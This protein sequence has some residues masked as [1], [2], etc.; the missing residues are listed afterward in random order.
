MATGLEAGIARLRARHQPRVCDDGDS[1]T[2]FVSRLK[3][4]REEFKRDHPLPPLP[5]GAADAAS[6]RQHVAPSPPPEEMEE[7]PPPSLPPPYELLVESPDGDV[8]PYLVDLLVYCLVSGGCDRAAPPARTGAHASIN[9]RERAGR[10]RG[11]RAFLPGSF[12][13]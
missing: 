11:P 10:R 1:S 4:D 7:A 6:K 3:R 8:K 2:E 12:Y 5:S 13:A 9:Q